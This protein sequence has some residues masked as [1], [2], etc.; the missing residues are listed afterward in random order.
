MSEKSVQIIV[1]KYNQPEYEARTI[2]SVARF[3]KE[4]PYTLTAIQN[5]LGVGLAKCWNQII[6]RS[7]VIDEYICLLN[8]DTV[9][10]NKWLSRLLSTFDEYPECGAVVPSSNNAAEVTIPVPFSHAE[11]NFNTINDFGQS[12]WDQH[13][14]ATTKL[15]VLSATCLVFPRKVW[16]EAGRFDEDFFLYGE[17]SEFTWRIKNVLKR[18]LIWR[19]GVYVHHYKARSVIKAVEEGEFKLEDVRAEATRLWREKTGKDPKT[20]ARL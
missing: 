13:E 16:R 7:S 19:K 14:D 1:V 8:S 5:P 17:D 9:V 20:G 11:K 2:E 10:T 15:D 4:I 3:T 6:R 18:E 12:W